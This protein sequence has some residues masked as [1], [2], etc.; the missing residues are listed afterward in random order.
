MYKPHK[1][2]TEIREHH[3]G[4]IEVRAVLLV[5]GEN[6]PKAIHVHVLDVEAVLDAISAKNEFQ[7]LAAVLT[8]LFGLVEIA[9]D[10]FE[11]A[12][13]IEITPE[14][15]FGRPEED[16]DE[17]PE[18]PAPKPAAK[19]KTSKK[20]VAAIDASKLLLPKTGADAP[21]ELPSK[22]A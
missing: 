22:A 9:A 7:D 17:D 19:K 5:H 21:P 16:E 1:H 4:A 20:K 12:H 15:V 11:D 3:D 13:K 2:K 14:N 6:G 8:Q 18:P 10:K